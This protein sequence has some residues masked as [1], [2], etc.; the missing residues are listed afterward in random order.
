MKDNY[1]LK[2][3]PLH[4]ALFFYSSVSIDFI[5]TGHLVTMPSD[6]K[7]TPMQK[8]DA[9][10]DELKMMRAV[11]N[12]VAAKTALDAALGTPAETVLV[13]PELANAAGSAVDVSAFTRAI[14]P[15]LDLQQSL[16]SQRARVPLDR[17]LGE[18]WRWRAAYTSKPSATELADY[19]MQDERSAPGDHDQAI[20]F[21]I[22]PLGLWFA[23]EGKNRVHFLRSG[24]AIEMPAMVNSV[25]YPACDRLAIYRLAITGREE[26]WC[27][28]D[29][30]LAKRLLLPKLTQTLLRA[31]GVSPVSTWPHNL[32]PP[33]MIA[34][35]LQQQ[36]R[37]VGNGLDIDLAVLRERIADNA[38]GETFTELSLLD[39]LAS[40]LLR[41]RW[42]WIA[43]ASVICLGGLA[44]SMAWPQPWRSEIQFLT[45]GVIG[46]FVATLTIPWM[47]IR[48][49]HLRHDAR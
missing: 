8:P 27:V 25:D 48:R 5:F 40:G 7:I 39:A 6:T 30:R 2:F 21:E 46:G 35:A 29:G 41:T 17:L 11:R 42:R 37:H 23:H 28:L 33:H 14:V 16:G 34:D 19:L 24:G 22:A 44:L 49:K 47:R 32:P 3:E 38:S 9:A 31:Y 1:R 12:I 15:F 10:S 13:L 36:E 45:V 26:L 18:S 4:E 43:S 20:V